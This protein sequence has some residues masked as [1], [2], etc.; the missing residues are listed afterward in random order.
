MTYEEALV[1]VHQYADAIDAYF[2]VTHQRNFSL[3]NLEDYKSLSEKYPSDE[4]FDQYRFKEKRAS[5]GLRSDDV[6]YQ[7][8]R[9]CVQRDLEIPREIID[10]L[11][12]DISSPPTR[13]LERR[14]SQIATMHI[15]PEIL[16]RIFEFLKRIEATAL[17]VVRSN[18]KQNSYSFFPGTVT[19]VT[20]GLI[21]GMK[22]LRPNFTAQ[23]YIDETRDHI[24]YCLELKLPE[25]FL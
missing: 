22:M 21:E 19:H 16:E 9:R 15:D 12:G 17:E 23:K 4:E 5:S 14:I 11:L 25:N 1:L 13:E 3:V 8:I 10:V 20:R 18:E 6:M 2:Q 7:L 24:A